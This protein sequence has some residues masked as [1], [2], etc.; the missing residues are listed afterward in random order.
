MAS[1]STL[2]T[3]I[4]ENLATI[5]GL[6]VSPT[7]QIPE[8]VNPPY[9]IITPNAVEYH[10]AFNNALNTYNFTITVVVGRA[11]ARSAQNALDAYCSPTGSSSIKGAVESDRELDGNS[12]SL[13]V[14]RM[15]NYGSITI[16]E[17]NYLAA[18]F[19]LVVQAD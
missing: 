7:G 19:D 17:T 10:K 2:R 4:A 5:S 16:G 9:A 12:Y 6:R 8:N 11:D 15:R 18:E 1:I 14:T 13:I 3:K